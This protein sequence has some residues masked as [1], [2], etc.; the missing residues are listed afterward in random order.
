V[1]AAIKAAKAPPAKTAALRAQQKQAPA[2]KDW[3]QEDD[4]EPRRQK[5]APRGRPPKGRE[6]VP[7]QISRLLH[8]PTTASSSAIWYSVPIGSPS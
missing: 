8:V 1:C 3:D 2:D 5:R 7:V 4:E 6:E